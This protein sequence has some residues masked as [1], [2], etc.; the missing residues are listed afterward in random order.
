MQHQ[1]TLVA[2]LATVWCVATVYRYH[3]AEWR[4]DDANELLNTIQNEISLVKRSAL[5]LG[6]AAGDAKQPNAT[7]GGHSHNSATKAPAK[8]SAEVKLLSLR[9]GENVRLSPPPAP[10]PPPP[11]APTPPP[12][13]HQ[14]RPLFSAVVAT[15]G[16]ARR[17]K[18]EI[19]KQTGATHLWRISRTS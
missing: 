12:R 5:E 17:P 9:Q 14:P 4:R 2:V 6:L 16:H 18:Q 19:S 1:R 13:L 15:L 8:G 3:T 7:G 11:P 10:P